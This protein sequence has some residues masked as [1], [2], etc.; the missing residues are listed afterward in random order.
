MYFSNSIPSLCYDNKLVLNSHEL[1]A[2]EIETA[3]DKRDEYIIKTSQH[4]FNYFE[5][6]SLTDFS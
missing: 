1:E 4:K 3:D 5:P 2:Q 6:P